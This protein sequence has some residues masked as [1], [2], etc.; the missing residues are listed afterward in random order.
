V[1]AASTARAQDLD[2][3]DVHVALDRALPVAFAR[4]RADGPQ[5]M[6]RPFYANLRIR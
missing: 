3:S 4:P 2:T 5:L 6:R 1:T